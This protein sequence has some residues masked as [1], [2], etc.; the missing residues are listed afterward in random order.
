MVGAHLPACLPARLPVRL[1]VILTDAPSSLRITQY[2]KC[3]RTALEEQ[4]TQPID[5]LEADH[6]RNFGFDLS[7]GAGAGSGTTTASAGSKAADDQAA[8][9]P[10]NSG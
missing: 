2:I 8:G 6:M 10:A 7:K 5:P 1:F 4:P 3:H 9:K